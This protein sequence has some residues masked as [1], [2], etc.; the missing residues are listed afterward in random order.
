L[1][2]LDFV[3]R[4]A[5]HTKPGWLGT[6]NHYTV[7]PDYPHYYSNY[8]A[9]SYRYRRMKQRI[10]ENESGLSVD[11][12]WSIQRDTKNLMAEAVTP[13]LIDAF[14]ASEETS[15]LAKILRDWDL[16]DTIDQSGPT[17][18]Q[19][20]YCEFAEAVY[21]DELGE[22][23]T[24]RMLGNW[25]F[26]QERFERM[27]LAGESRWFDDQST[28]D[29]TETMGDMIQ[30]GGRQAIVRL[31]PQ[32]GPDLHSWDWGRVHTIQFVNP[33]RRSGIGRDWLGTSARPVN[34][35][36]ETLYR[37]WYNFNDPSQ[38]TFAAALRMVVD[39]GDSEK[40]RAVLA[41]GTTGRTFHPH[42]KD[43]IDAYLSGEPKH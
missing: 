20:V 19:A 3:R 40:V 16:H 36:G 32:L 18:F 39:F 1:A 23:L 11:D 43:Q 42:Q 4:N 25:Y 17:I 8:A 34:G 7:P 2:R 15:E 35:S 21:S 12:H 33:I 24:Q 22:E 37:G 26:W 28:P 5:S 29:V 31:S 9:P 10:A 27:V 30:R 13:I 38:V 41:G 6:A 14:A